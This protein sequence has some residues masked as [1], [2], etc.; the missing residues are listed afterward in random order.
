MPHLPS[1]VE[2]IRGIKCFGTVEHRHA[3]T[4]ILAERRFDT[5]F[6]LTNY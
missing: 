1:R 6:S 3:H 2:T 4:G 5:S